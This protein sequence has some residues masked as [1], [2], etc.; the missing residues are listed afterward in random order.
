MS[1][2]DPVKT[3][4]IVQIARILTILATSD[5]EFVMGRVKAPVVFLSGQ[6]AAHQQRDGQAT[7]LSPAE[8]LGIVSL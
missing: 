5:K 6:Q 1:P 2:G 8:T 7:T 3:E 4:V